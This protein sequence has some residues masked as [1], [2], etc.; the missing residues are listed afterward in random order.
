MKIELM[1]QYAVI[2]VL[3]VA[4][5]LFTVKKLYTGAKSGGCAGG[6]D[7]CGSCGPVDAPAGDA[8]KPVRFFAHKR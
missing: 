2:A 6:C 1:L 3:L 7:A 5:V 4:C 8:V